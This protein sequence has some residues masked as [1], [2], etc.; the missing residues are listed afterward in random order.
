LQAG[1][2]REGTAPFTL[3][4]WE[5]LIVRCK[6]VK[7]IIHGRL[8]FNDRDFCEGPGDQM[9]IALLFILFF[10]ERSCSFSFQVKVLSFPGTD[11]RKEY[12]T[13]LKFTGRF[14]LFAYRIPTV[15]TNA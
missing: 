10:S 2:L 7:P 8:E 1:V 9:D 12:D 4:A 5:I 3:V 13:P 11:P 6:G 15:K 14:I